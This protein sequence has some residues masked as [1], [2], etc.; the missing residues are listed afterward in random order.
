MFGSDALAGAIN[1]IQA[2]HQSSAALHALAEVGERGQHRYGLR[3]T[4]PLPDAAAA[5]WH[6]ALGIDHEDDGAPVTGS[7]YDGRSATFTVDGAWDRHTRLSLRGRAADSHGTTFPD[8]SGGPRLAVIRDSDNSRKDEFSVAA[9]L[10]HAWS[11]AW[12]SAITASRL[13]R[14]DDTRS[15]GV[16][17][18]AGAFVPP[19]TSDSRFRA[20]EVAW[21]N[22][23]EAA[24]FAVDFGAEWTQEDGRLA[25]SVAFAPGVNVPQAYAIDRDTL[26]AF[27]ATSWRPTTAMLL[28]GS[29]RRDDADGAAAETT[30]QLGAV[31]DVAARTAVH[32]TW[33]QG[34]KVPSFFALANPFAGNRALQPETARSLDAGV[35]HAFSDTV[36]LRTFAFA[37]RYRRLIDFDPDLFRLVNRSRVDIRGMELSLE[38]TASTGTTLRGHATHT[39]VDVDGGGRLVQRPRWRGGVTVQQSLA[40]DWKLTLHGLFIGDSYDAAIPTGGLDLDGYS[41][42]DATLAWQPTSALTVRLAVDN[43][44]NGDYEEAVGFAAPG[45]RARL[46]LTASL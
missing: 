33:G 15:P 24:D 40:S 25:G 42:F 45:R 10:S 36:S 43:A 6:A 35:V 11:D 28:R 2:P 16:A 44:G 29:L 21:R 1:L 26:G 14:D 19:N 41:R 7:R 5:S 31:I 46:S 22:R 27:V 20:R 34:F 17:E 9:T 38:W 8:D 18:N 12:S 32:V 39:D 4:T 3:G 23:Y 30:A 37:S 13:Q